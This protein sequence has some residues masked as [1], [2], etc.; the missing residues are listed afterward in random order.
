MRPIG[1]LELAELFLRTHIGP[2]EAAAFAR[3]IGFLLALE[4]QPAAFG[5]AGLVQDVAFD[6]E[7]PAVI[8]AA[9]AALFIASEG[10]RGAAV[11]AAF[12]EHAEPSLGIA[13]DDEV[14]AQ[15]ARADGRTIGRGDLFRQ[16][17]RQ[18]MAAHDL[19]HRRSAFDAGE[20]IVVFPGDHDACPKY[21]GL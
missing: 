17:G 18:P 9:Q 3:R 16:A 11:H 21:L 1:R 14:F 2:D 4:F 12:G 19:A 6:V 8:E 13:E 5:L 20:Q 15:H 7:F 10:E